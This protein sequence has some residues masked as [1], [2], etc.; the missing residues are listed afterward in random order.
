[1]QFT[2]VVRQLQL[3]TMPGVL[4]VKLVGERFERADANRSRLPRTFLGW[5]RVPLL[6]A[7]FT[8][9][10]NTFQF[11][12]FLGS[13][14]IPVR[15]AGHFR[16]P[17]L[18][19]R[20]SRGFFQ[21]T[22][23]DPVYWQKQTFVC[24]TLDVLLPKAQPKA[25]LQAL[26]IEPKDG[27]YIAYL[28]PDDP[29]WYLDKYFAIGQFKGFDDNGMNELR[30]EAL[31]QG[32]APKFQAWS[33]ATQRFQLESGSIDMVLFSD[34][35]MKRLGA[36]LEPALLEVKRVLRDSGRF[37]F[38]FDDV[39]EELSGSSFEVGLKG[40]II[41]RIGFEL[42][43]ANRGECGVV[44]GYFRK[45]FARASS[46]KRLSSRKATKKRSIAKGRE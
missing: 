35:A 30:K 33:I 46:G 24:E 13:T 34:G 11:A 6:L 36:L 3:E 9:A 40:S 45:K 38:V 27:K 41:D 17:H 14:G 42:V 31:A 22:W 16:A 2:P 25:K 37:F 39:D 7:C 32:A 10:A 1:V 15:Y 19:T 18:R 26:E 20:T 5:Y 8:A 43:A 28:K 12:L 29:S 4:P 23:A 21:G 44:V